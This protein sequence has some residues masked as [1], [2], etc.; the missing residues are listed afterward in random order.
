[1]RISVQNCSRY[2]ELVA[3]DAVIQRCQAQQE[4]VE[5][6]S[7]EESGAMV[8]EGITIRVCFKHGAFGMN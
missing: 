8:G 5:S 6:S 3:N 4:K 2:A 7:D 1:M